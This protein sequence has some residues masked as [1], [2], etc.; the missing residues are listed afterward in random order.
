[1]AV[2]RS[3]YIIIGIIVLAAF[4]V[5]FYNLANPSHYV[6]IEGMYI[7]S[8]QNYMKTGH[9]GPD[10]WYTP[11][12]KKIVPFLAMKIFGNNAFAWRF[13]NA[14]S[15]SLSVL[16]LYLLLREIF[17]KSQPNAVTVLLPPVLLALDPLHIVFSRTYIEDIYAVF[18]YL[19]SLLFFLKYLRNHK[20]HH[21]AAAGVS[22]GLAFAARWYVLL[23]ILLVTVL[24]LHRFISRKE[25]NL[26]AVLPF[27]VFMYILPL[28]I[29][30]WT[31]Y[32]WFAERGYTLGE[33]LVYQLAMYK[34]QMGV[35]AEQFVY[36]KYYGNTI[37][38]SDWF[39]KIIAFAYGTKAGG[40]LVSR[41]IF[42]NN[43]LVWLLAI[44]AQ[45]ILI[46]AIF[47][48]ASKYRYP[49]FFAAANFWIYYVPL[50]FAK[51]PILIY[52]SL[53]VLPFAF[54]GISF[55]INHICKNIRSNYLNILFFSVIII[56]CLQA[57]YLF[58]L[59]TATPVSAQAY[60]GLF[61][62]LGIDLNL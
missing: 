47:S 28:T 21:L 20:A 59:L 10:N 36:G 16:V 58:P 8:T 55:A 22:I 49:Y 9:F 54:I 27:L 46:V 50:L 30:L 53:A 4:F 60:Q 2:N 51:R 33:W 5:R 61:R 19:C 39:S 29:Y 23:G 42:L 17:Y 15:G 56:Y 11:P 31:F 38:A 13:P 14:L 6:G 26:R 41:I 40:G 12:L 52:T 45:I 18:L 3:H 35:S 62:F 34:T 24:F 25:F 32:P 57:I 7:E 37:N 48:G 44:P 43:P 1:M